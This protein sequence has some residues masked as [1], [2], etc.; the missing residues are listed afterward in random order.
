[1]GCQS[2]VFDLS[3]TFDQKCLRHVDVNVLPQN[4]PERQEPSILSL[5][6]F[7]SGQ[8]H[9]AMGQKRAPFSS[10]QKKGP[11]PSPQRVETGTRVRT[12]PLSELEKKYIYRL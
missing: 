7:G 10:H 3:K 9:A 8:L 4:R 5:V 2:F 1:M 11:D 12:M 6:L